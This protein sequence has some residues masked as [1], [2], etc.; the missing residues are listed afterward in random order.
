MG[1]QQ[2]AA[3]STG[4]TSGAPSMSVKAM[5]PDK[6]NYEMTQSGFREWCR[7]MSDWLS[8]G[9][10]SGDRALISIRLNCDEKLRMAIDSAYSEIHWNSLS[11]NEAFDKLEEIT[12]KSVNRAVAWDR[13]F[14]AQQSEQEPAK[15]F[16]HRCQQLAI[17]CGFKCPYCRAD[18]NDFVLVQRVT[19]G[20]TNVGLKQEILQ[21]HDKFNTVPKLIRKCEAYESATKDS[22]GSRGRSCV[23]GL[24]TE[25]ATDRPNST[26]EC[27]EKVVAGNWP[28]SQSGAKG[29]SRPTRGN[30][31]KAGPRVPSSTKMCKDCGYSHAQD[32]C[33]AKNVRC[34]GCDVKGHL[35]RQCPKE[36]N[37][38]TPILDASVTSC[39]VS[40]PPAEG[41]QVCAAVG[42]LPVVKACIMHDFSTQRVTVELVPDTGAEVCIVGASVLP[43]WGLCLEALSKCNAIVNH[44][45]E[46]SLKVYGSVNIV[47][48]LGKRSVKTNVIVVQ[49][50]TRFYASLQVCKSLGLVHENFP[51]HVVTR[52]S[53]VTHKPMKHPCQTQ[54][55]TTKTH[56]VS[57]PSELPYP[58]TEENVARLK[59]WLL[60]RFANTTFNT[61]QNPLPM[62]AGAPHHIHLVDGAIPYACHTPIP[63]PKHWEADVKRQ[64]DEDVKLGVIREVPAGIATD[65]C[66]RMV[67]VAKKNGTPRRTVDYQ[68][69]NKRCKRETHH[70]FAPFDMVSSVPLRTY[71]TVVDAYSGFHQVDL[72]EESRQLTTFITPWGRY[73]YCRTPMG[74]CSAQ[75]AYTKRFDDIIIDVPRKYKCVD[76]VLLYDDS[77]DGAFW[78]TFDFLQLCERNGVTLHPDKFRFCQRQT[79]FVG[80]ELDWDNYRP[81]IERMSAIKNFPMPDSPTIT[82][83]RSWFGLVNQVAPFVAIAPVMEPFRELLKKS[84]Y[85]KVYWDQRLQDSFV[86]ARDSICKLLGD[87]LT[88]YDKTRRTAVVT[89]WCKDGMG[90]VILQQ[91]CNCEDSKAPFCCRGGWKLA[92]CGSRHLSDAEAGYAVVEGEAAAVV[93][94][95]RKARLF[96][97][98]CPNFLLITDHRPLVKLFGDRSLKDIANPR[99]LRLKEKTLLYSFTVKYI[100]GKKNSAADTLSRYPVVRSK[101]TIDDDEEDG[102]LNE[103]CI[104]SMTS[105]L[106]DDVITVDW[107]TLSEVA[108][109]DPDYQLLRCHVSEGSWPASRSHVEPCLKPYFG[110]RDRLS[111]VDGLVTYAVDAGHVRLV[112]P[113]ALRPRVM[114]NL[115]SGHQSADSMLRRARQAVY[116]PGIDGDLEGHRARCR[117]CNRVAPSQQR[118]SIICTP[119]PEY[120]FQKTVAD[121][122]QVAGRHYMAYADRLTGWIEI[123]FFA[124]ETTSAR[125]IPVFRKYFMQW[126]APEE[127]SMDEGTNLTSA[128]MRNFFRRWGVGM[129]VS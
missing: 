105:S 90:F 113:E 16:V 66:A 65:W 6:C 109:Q 71:K 52:V 128:E 17:D 19:S 45:G 91:H 78:H 100:P 29:S 114:D 23:A 30:Y 108:D 41:Q 125:L 112:V 87:G 110:V 11:I 94:C 39:T 97:L 80:Y 115:H 120:P 55:K 107:N 35:R 89:D 119:P 99:L 7:S 56:E 59:G 68:E 43:T 129:R 98:G 69:L 111:I 77:V 62:M 40:Y 103:A 83:I 126:G 54:V 15:A 42:K 122:F 64:L 61:S 21:N 104:A 60:Q 26:S 106:A 1:R 67:V 101:T 53:D 85:R 51:H 20:L 70:T 118:E 127:I 31:G 38:A 95:L 92:L 22:M 76:D 14:S 24:Q 63:I 47:V 72:D 50:A 46:K 2:N 81:S 9:N 84:P 116:W 4:A 8:L 124:N 58:A 79:E 73:Q 75:D 88:Y 102:S 49:G 57:R 3:P 13:F 32:Q 96:L 34:Y 93:W 86:A 18:L 5:C 36:S 74:H 82:D 37:K 28:R 117:A 33:P 25:D 121:L 123:Y 12:T 48:T 27:D 44:A 10:V